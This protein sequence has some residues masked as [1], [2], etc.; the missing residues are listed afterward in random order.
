VNLWR[1]EVLRLFRTMRW[2]GLLASYLA[3]GIIGPVI[4]R[5]QEALFRNVGGGVKI[6]APPPTP[7][8]AVSSYI[9]NAAQIGLIVTIFIA[10]GSLAFDAKPEWAAFLRTRA[11]SMGDVV[12]P[13][14]AVNAAAAAGSFALG[15]V[16]AWV[17]T[18]LLIDRVDPVAVVL[19]IVAWALYLAFAVSVVALAAG[20]SRSVVG[21]A[22][23]TVVVL[24]ALPL[25]AQVLHVVEPWMPS[26]LV[27][28]VVDLVEGGSAADYLPAAVSAV[29]C[30]GVAL[31]AS[32]RLLARRE[33]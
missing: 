3:F 15:M 4:T 26:T 9:G 8:L 12:V 2:L 6:E 24:L 7:A 19:G 1:L 33:L 16:A 28:A 10:A 27:G 30:T 23:I 13:K 20:L 22:G 18:A 21:T 11:R 17:V 25:G 32:T 5:Y 14:F 31:W 29:V